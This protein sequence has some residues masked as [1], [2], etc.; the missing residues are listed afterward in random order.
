[1]MRVAPLAFVLTLAAVPALAAPTSTRGNADLKKYCT[2]D[3]LKL[4]GDIDP[5]DPAMDAC[6]KKNRG[7][8]TENCR[9]AIDAYAGSGG[10]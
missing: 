4:C 5:D 6:F 3:A 9:R 10:K 2:G 8:L 1:M 7:A